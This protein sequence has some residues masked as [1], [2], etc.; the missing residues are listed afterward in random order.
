MVEFKVEIETRIEN[1]NDECYDVGF[2]VTY[3]NTLMHRWTTSLCDGSHR[4][5]TQWQARYDRCEEINSSI[6]EELTLARRVSSESDAQ[7]WRVL[8]YF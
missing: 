3:S 6:T 7:I 8:E 1:T 4:T 5:K 2:F